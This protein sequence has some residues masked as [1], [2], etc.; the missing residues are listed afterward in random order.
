MA[1]RRPPNLTRSVR[2]A[3]KGMAWLTDSD[4]AAVDLALHYAAEIE[5]AAESGDEAHRAKVLGWHG[6]H[7]LNTLKALGG[8][9]GDRKALGAETEVKGRLGELRALRGA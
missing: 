7:L 2:S 8:T 5:S 9:P 3:V 1:P 4:R 6:P